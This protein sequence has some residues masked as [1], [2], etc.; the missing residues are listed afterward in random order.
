MIKA[1]VDLNDGKIVIEPSGS[2]NDVLHDIIVFNIASARVV[3]ELAE[4]NE[5]EILDSVIE[6]LS[7]KRD[8]LRRLLFVEK[9]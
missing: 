9:V 2:L 4:V 6:F 7:D 3:A 1:E 8:E 5:D